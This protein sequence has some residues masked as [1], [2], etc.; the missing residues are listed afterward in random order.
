MSR[1]LRPF[2]E[3]VKQVVETQLAPV[4][5]HKLS[6]KED[7]DADCDPMFRIEWVSQEGNE[8]GVL[9]HVSRA[10]SKLCRFLDRQD[11][12]C[13]KPKCLEASLP[14]LGSRIRKGSVQEEVRYG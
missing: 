8:H 7:V 14:C 10:M 2:N 13:K 3:I 5:V 4:L 6:V 12:G 9:R 1:D 11:Q